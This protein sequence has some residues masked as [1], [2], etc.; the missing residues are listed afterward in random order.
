[1]HKF[2]CAWWRRRSLT[3][4]PKAVGWLD[5][6]ENE[7]D[8]LEKR[9]GVVPAAG[10]TTTDA[11]LRSDAGMF[12]GHSGVLDRGQAVARCRGEGVPRSS[13]QEQTAVQERKLALMQNDLADAQAIAT[14][15]LEVAQQLERRG[16]RGGLRQFARQPEPEKREL[17][18]C[19]RPVRPIRAAQPGRGT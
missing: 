9:I 15:S 5:R 8:N 2:S 12:L 13:S 19:P 17:L 3:L 14:R 7:I 4:G 6:L 10:P 1:M 18:D 16:Y 11:V